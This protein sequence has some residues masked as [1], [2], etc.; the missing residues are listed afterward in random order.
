MFRSNFKFLFAPLLVLLL[1][2]TSFSQSPA[3]VE[4]RILAKLQT[5]SDTGTYGGSYSDD[6][7]KRNGDANK[8]LTALLVKEGSR[9]EILKYAFPK[10]KDKMGVATSKDGKLR[11]YSWDTETGG[12]M[13]HYSSVVQYQGASG[14]VDTWAYDPSEVETDDS[15]IPS[16]IGVGGYY[17]RIVQFDTPK[18][19]IYLAISLSI[20]CG[21]CHGQGVE[22][23][24]I[25]GDS[26]IREAKV[27]K[28][29][30]GLTNSIDF[31]YAPATIPGK[32]TGETLVRFNAATKSFSIPV[33]LDDDESGNGRVTTRT[34]TYRFN[35]TYFLKVK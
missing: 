17:M 5:L 11:I 24:R 26:L 1:Y 14:K 3:Q 27:I 6:D 20:G 31:A 19:P 22:A 25:D 29:A 35:G 9:A 8:E 12:T 30:S 4:S 7:G 21:Q 23:A 15:P 28:T 34:I 2:A 16:G 33:V 10:L 32:L 13:H 18:G